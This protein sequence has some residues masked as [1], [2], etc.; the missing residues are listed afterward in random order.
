[1][2]KKQCPR[3]MFAAPASGSGKTTLTMGLLGALIA[4]G[5]RP[6]SFKCGPDYIDPMFHREVLGVPGGNLDLFFTNAD[7][8]AGLLRRYAADA[9]IAVLEGVMGYYDGVGAT[10]E[11]SSWRLASATDTPAILVLRPKGAFL[12][13]AAAVN[14][15]LRFRENSMLR[16]IVLNRCGEA[17]YRKLAPMLERETGL[18][19]YGHL[20]DVPEASLESR[21]LG[22]V[23]PDAVGEL[24]EKVRRLSA[25]AENSLDIP[26]LIE[27]AQS[28][29]ALAA[30]LPVIAPVE[31]TPVRIAV[32]RDEAFCFYYRENLDL[33]RS[34][35][36]ELVFFSPLRDETLPENIGGLYLGGG[37][38]EL[39]AK[40]LAANAA[41]RLA[42]GNAVASGL[43]AVAECGG[44]LYLQ[45]NLADADDREHEM[46]GA[47][48]GTGRNA[49]RLRRF[50]Y[51]RLEARHDTLLC[52]KGEEMPAHEFHYW[53]S[54]NPGDSFAATK[55]AGD[56]VWDCI[57]ARGNLF[58]GF[59]HL[60]FWSNPDLARRFVRAAA[61]RA[62]V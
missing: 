23:T 37:Y 27:L 55:A 46:V 12:S 48:P 60:Y 22:L 3:I 59:P 51:V 31:E 40:E 18:R 8:A 20:P 10:P 9:D 21:H 28:A 33:L 34:F 5:V 53:D 2:K 52:G 41:M 26:G 35:G 54:D 49:R 11:A 7:I 56:A 25:E 36:A 16:G 24:R 4:R 45:S 38:P 17:L 47:L 61:R 50:G 44:F 58:A 1:M 29:P 42:V 43:P 57:V 32:A 13:L 19:L 62:G 39:H 30:S 6:A 15:F 14:G